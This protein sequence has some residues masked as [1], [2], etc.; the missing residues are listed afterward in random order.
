MHL[1]LNR[2]TGTLVTEAI[3][4]A[5]DRGYHS[6][7]MCM[8]TKPAHIP[9]DMLREVKIQMARWHP[10]GTPILHT[11]AWIS[12]KIQEGTVKPRIISH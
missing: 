4:I 2:S 5:P 10:R 3:S 12:L 9:H 11:S 1:I 6:E 7:S 8:Q